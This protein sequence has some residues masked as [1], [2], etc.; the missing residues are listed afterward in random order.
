MG[1]SGLSALINL[2]RRL[3]KGNL[4]AQTLPLLSATTLLPIQRRP[5]KIRPIAIGT[6]PRQLVTKVPL[7]PAVTDTQGFLA[8]DQLPSSMTPGCTLSGMAAILST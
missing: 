7:G 4:P 6:A 2:V 8:P 5:D 1:V 3:A